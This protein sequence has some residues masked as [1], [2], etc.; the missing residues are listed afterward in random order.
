MWVAPSVRQPGHQDALVLVPCLEL[1]LVWGL[2]SPRRCHLWE[3]PQKRGDVRPLCERCSLSWVPGL[4]SQGWLRAGSAS[5]GGSAPPGWEVGE[6]CVLR[7][8]QCLRVSPSP[9]LVLTTGTSPVGGE[10]PQQELTGSLGRTGG[11][12]PGLCRVLC[13]EEGQHWRPECPPVPSVHS[14]QL[15]SIQGRTTRWLKEEGN[16][17]VLGAVLVL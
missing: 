8:E 2:H 5:Q 11:L 6:P 4:L 17:K 15:C 12:M 1:S 3:S 14:S 13:P 10:R 9:V 16:R 7:S